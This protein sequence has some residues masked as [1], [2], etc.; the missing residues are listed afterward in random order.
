MADRRLFSD[1]ERAAL[2]LAAGGLCQRCG[3]ELGDDW[4]ADHIDPW[5]ESQVTDAARGQA[6]CR[7]CNRKKADTREPPLRMWQERALDQY[8]AT[9]SRDFLL[10]ATPGAG[11][12]RFA[13]E[14]LRNHLRGKV[15]SRVAVVVPT[16]RLKTQWADRL[17]EL[18]I[19]THPRWENAHGAWP[20]GMAGVVVTYHQVVSQPDLF[21]KHSSDRRT[22]VV[23]DEI[24]HC[25]DGKTWGDN[26]RHAF[27]HAEKRLALSGTPFRSDN[28][29]IPFVRYVDGQGVADFH[30]GYGEALAENVCRPVYFPLKGGLAEW[31]P[32][33][34]VYLKHSFAD[35]LPEREA[36]ERLRTVL[37]QGDWLP[38]V[39]ADAQVKLSELRGTDPDAACLALAID[40]SHARYVAQVV[41]SV[42]GHDPV[43]VTS[44]EAEA[45]DRI[46][47]FVHG[48]EPWLVAIK[49]VSEG[50]D[51][52]RLRVGVY[53]T[54]V[55]SELFFR[56]AVGRLLRVEEDGPDAHM[57]I[58]DDPRL[59]F[60]AEEIQKQRD[61]ALEQEERT[62]REVEREGEITPSSFVPLDSTAV[63]SGVTF[64]GE[65]FDAEEIAA[66]NQIRLRDPDTANIEPA[67][68]AKF[69]RNAGLVLSVPRHD[70]EA[71]PLYQV[72]AGLR[73]TVSKRARSIAYSLQINPGV[74]HSELNKQTGCSNVANA[75]EEQ[76]RRQLDLMR[77]WEEKG[78]VPHVW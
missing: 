32:R 33:E 66:V 30:Y 15:V 8:T 45:G 48:S 67:I 23:L 70:P 51:I 63:D 7:R 35:D 36:N 25:G 49:M 13:G 75:T 47:R 72:R 20:E 43:V 56:Q 39:I 55:T 65:H 28:N 77:E 16:D 73:K 11:K 1:R 78:E 22:F 18:G 69:A 74:L 4:E 71:R 52:P 3:E 50:V 61:H 58:P 24:H 6:L 37:Q 17:A 53:A 42:T 41:K 64:A 38:S 26:L 59:R 14:I 27:E 5:S 19:Q 57:F 10:V 54:N 29:A 76:L 40:E 44:Q 60:W 21:R 68:L 12:T 34:G 62:L 31:S 46:D 2:Y 9:N